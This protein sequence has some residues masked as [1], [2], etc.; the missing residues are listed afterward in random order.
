MQ[1][2]V[3]TCARERRREAPYLVRSTP[4]SGG[5]VTPLEGEYSPPR[6]CFGLATKGRQR[7]CRGTSR[8]RGPG[9]GAGPHGEDSGDVK[10]SQGRERSRFNPLFRTA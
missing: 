2:I 10:A 7:S 6:V 5:R 8:R 1:K 4:Q 9:G 3:S